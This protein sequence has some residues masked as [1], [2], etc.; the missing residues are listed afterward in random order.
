MIFFSTLDFGVLISQNILQRWFFGESTEKWR[1]VFIVCSNEV[2]FCWNT[3]QLLVKLASYYSKHPGTLSS[4]I[5]MGIKIAIPLF[6]GWITAVSLLHAKHL[7]CRPD[8]CPYIF[9]FCESLRS[10]CN[11]QLYITA[12]CRPESAEYSKAQLITCIEYGCYTT[13]YNV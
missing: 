2:G 11:G 8:D 6:G 5:E 13:L 3:F 10:L 4:V 12:E 7:C 1:H 9:S